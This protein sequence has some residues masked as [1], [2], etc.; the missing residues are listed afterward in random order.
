MDLPAVASPEVY[1]EWGI[2]WLDVDGWYF[3]RFSSPVGLVRWAREN[4]FKL[5]SGP[6][7]V[8]IKSALKPRSR[9][10]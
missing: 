10:N 7:Q 8:A 2:F 3:Q 6:G 1:E 9:L 4:S 5:P